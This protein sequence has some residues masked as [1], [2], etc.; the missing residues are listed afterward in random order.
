MPNDPDFFEWS[1]KGL[2]TLMLTAGGWFVATLTK[3]VSDTREDLADHKLHVSE[4][5]AKTDSLERIHDRI[6]EVASD[7][8]T[9]LQRK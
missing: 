5:Y 7:I 2:V 1:F 3:S 4:N 8:K 9:L 6:D